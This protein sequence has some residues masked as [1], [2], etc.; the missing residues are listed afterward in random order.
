MVYYESRR[1]GREV[2][3]AFRGARL[4]PAVTANVPL[5]PRRFPSDDSEPAAFATRLDPGATE[6]PL[7]WSRLVYRTS[8]AVGAWN[9]CIADLDSANTARQFPEHPASRGLERRYR[10]LRSGGTNG[11]CKLCVMPYS[12]TFAIS[13]TAGVVHIRASAIIICLT[14]HR[15]S[16]PPVARAVVP[17]RSPPRQPIGVQAAASRRAASRTLARRGDARPEKQPTRL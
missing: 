7:R 16:L 8:H 6:Q 12:A 17:D 13:Q 15:G 1:G 2:P 5:L 9:P 3:H 4:D 14:L 11:T 10:D